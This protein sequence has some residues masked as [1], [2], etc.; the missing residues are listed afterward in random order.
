LHS[1]FNRVHNGSAQLHAFTSLSQL[2][3][4]ITAIVRAGAERQYVYAYWPEF[5]RLAHEHGAASPEVVGH[6]AELDAAFERFL[7]RIRGTGTTVIVTADHGFI[8]ARED[9]AIELD[10]H[11]ELAATL[12]LPLCGE[13]RTVYCYPRVDRQA[14]FCAYV[15]THLAAYADLRRSADLLDAGY[16]GLGPPHPRLH[17]R[18]GDYT[19]LMKDGA[20]LKDWLP[21][22]PRYEHVGVHGG[23]TAAEMYVPL[24]VAEE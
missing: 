4:A 22:E 16:F 13:R 3:K 10:D 1:E 18:I 12:L 15:R 5:D 24:I 11:P 7:A 20:T 2:F 23:M 9:R 8:D 21:G 6:L 17:E 14:E 19:L